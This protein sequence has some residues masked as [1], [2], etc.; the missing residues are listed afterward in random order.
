MAQTRAVRAGSLL[1]A[2]PEGR[3]VLLATVLGSAVVMLDGTV[4]NVAL[5]AIGRDLQAGHDGLWGGPAGHL[6]GLPGLVPLRRAPGAPLG[7]R[8]GFGIV[9]VRVA[10]AGLGGPTYTL[11]EAAVLGA[12]SPI[13]L[14]TGIG[15]VLALIGFLVVEARSSHPMLSLSLFASRQFSG[16]NL[17][18]L[19][20]Y[21]ALGAVFFLLILQLQQVVGYGPIQAGVATLPVTALMLVISP[22]AGKLASRIGPRIPLTG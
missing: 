4:V 2:S 12:G 7:P 16:T 21:G 20:V 14:L 15:G 13:I 22:R 8:R 19:A 18:T 9:V 1:Y 17:V 11:I 10:V 3:W 5:P 6:L